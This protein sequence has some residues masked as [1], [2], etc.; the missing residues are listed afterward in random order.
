VEA[1]KL[2]QLVQARTTVTFTPTNYI[3]KSCSGEADSRTVGE[4]MSYNLRNPKVLIVEI[5][6]LWHM[7]PCSLVAG[8]QRYGR[9]RLFHPKVD[10]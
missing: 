9:T 10:G 7:E 5:V 2:W 1:N 4:R 6:V 8:Y 3:E